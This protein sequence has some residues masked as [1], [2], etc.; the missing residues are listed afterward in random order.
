MKVLILGAKGLLGE[1]LQKAFAAHDVLARDRE[2]L[3]VT[4]FVR[5][6]SEIARLSPDAAINCVAWNDVDGAEAE[7]ERGGAHARDR[8][9]LLNCDVV[10]ELAKICSAAHLPLVTYSTDHV[11]N[12]EKTTGYT[13]DDRPNPINAYGRSKACGE[14]ALQEETSDFYLVR[15]S[16]LYGPKPR[17]PHAKSS[18]V[19]RMVELGA[20]NTQISVVDEEPGAFTFVKDLA[21]ATKKIVEEK[22]P[23][24]V[25]HL[26]A[27]GAAT[28]FE[29]AKEI[30]DFLGM[31][32]KLTPVRRKDFPRPAPIPACS[33]LLNTKFPRLR[34]W[35]DALYDFLSTYGKGL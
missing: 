15:T 13:E 34:D 16:R 20:H 9:R 31:E 21:E 35:K 19:L 22:F 18:F 8:A 3:D 26:T 17:S 27:D 2:E 1:A 28:W 32:I 10:K 30:F 12:G 6:R 11:F 14:A 23:Y 33:I 5:L 7:A 29:C 24:G 4:D 25:Y